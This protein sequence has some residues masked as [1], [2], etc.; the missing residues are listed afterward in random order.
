MV[1][2]VQRWVMYN[3]HG[4]TQNDFL[5]SLSWWNENERF[6][7]LFKFFPVKRLPSKEIWSSCGKKVEVFLLISVLFIF[8]IIFLCFSATAELFSLTFSKTIQPKEDTYHREF[9]MYGLHKSLTTR[10]WNMP[11]NL[12]VIPYHSSPTCSLSLLPVSLAQNFKRIFF[13][14]K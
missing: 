13:S 12:T 2:G 3:Q 5:H 6:I 8:F 7:G 9:R 11:D 10:R 14:C 1:E 4:Q